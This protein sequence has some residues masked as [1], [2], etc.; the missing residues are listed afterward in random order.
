MRAAAVTVNSTSPMSAMSRRN[1][2]R[3]SGASAFKCGTTG[4]GSNGQYPA[5][6]HDHPARGQLGDRRRQ[7]AGTAAFDPIMDGRQR[8]YFSRALA[9]MAV[10]TGAAEFPKFERMYVSSAAAS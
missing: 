7:R 10:S 1:W 4:S 8:H 2:A 3:A 9:I 6:A 5:L